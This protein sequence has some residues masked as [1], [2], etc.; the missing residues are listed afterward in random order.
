MPWRYLIKMPFAM[1]DIKTGK[2]SGCKKNSFEYYHEEAHI[3]FSKTEKGEFLQYLQ[4]T[5]H[6]YLL[7]CLTVSF[8]I[9]FFKFI[10]AILFIIILFCILYDELQANEYAN[11]Q[12]ERYLNKKKLRLT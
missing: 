11:K 7:G 8:F 6:T 9:N 4:E 10:S 12:I 3:R 2:I 1:S 5:S